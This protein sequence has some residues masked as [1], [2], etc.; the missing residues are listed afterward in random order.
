M[1]PLGNNEH[2]PQIELLEA[3]VTSYTGSKMTLLSFLMS[4]ATLC[5]VLYSFYVIPMRIEREKQSDIERIQAMREL[6]DST[7]LLTESVIR[8]ETQNVGTNPTRNP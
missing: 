1:K 2:R 6:A 7:R 8:M 5:A 4:C 3:S